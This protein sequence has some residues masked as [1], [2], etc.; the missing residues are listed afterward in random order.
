VKHIKDYNKLFENE[1]PIISY[2]FD[3]CLHV[4]VVGHDPIN[5][6][7]PESWVPFT[8]M[9]EQMREDAK[10]HT[11][12]ICTA[13]PPET[14][15]YVQ[16]F[17]DM[18]KLPVEKIYATNNFPK[19]PLLV[20][21]GAIKHYDDNTGL[22]EPLHKAGIEFVLV[23]PFNRTQQ[24]MEGEIPLKNYLI[25]FIND[26]FYISDNTIKAF[27]DRL[28]KLDPHMTHDP[29]S[30]GKGKNSRGIVIRS[31]ALSQPDIKDLFPEFTKKYDWLKMEVVATKYM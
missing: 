7:D 27:L 28:V 14:E 9:H 15:V 4:S 1:K 31:A 12:V 23:N 11:I 18:Y 19:T 13:R 22:I 5:F 3:G 10:T 17:L 30:D 29:R 20:E 6:T 26:K 24:V 21:I 8:E 2:D 25:T 16:E